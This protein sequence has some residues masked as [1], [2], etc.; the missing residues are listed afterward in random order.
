MRW[1][2]WPRSS[3]VVVEVVVLVVA[4]KHTLEKKSFRI[5][6]E[7]LGII[8]VV[9]GPP[10]VR[11]PWDDALCLRLEN[12]FVFLTQCWFVL[13]FRFRRVQLP[14]GQYYSLTIDLNVCV[15]FKGPCRKT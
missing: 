13:C 5:F 15:S 7:K 4:Q 14:I 9:D 12:P 3:T 11:P 6:C 1:Q 8:R 10:V 2:K